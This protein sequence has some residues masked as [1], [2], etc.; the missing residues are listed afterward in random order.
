MFP[1]GVEVENFQN[2][3]MRAYSGIPFIKNHVKCEAKNKIN[4][5][6]DFDSFKDAFTS[7]TIHT[8]IS[9]LRSF[10]YFSKDIVC[11]NLL[12]DHCR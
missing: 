6:A 3:E 9:N 12:K 5:V 7:N 2:E 11:K 8:V 1:Y 4:L 10:R